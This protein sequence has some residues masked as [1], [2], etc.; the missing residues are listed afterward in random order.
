M[1]DLSLKNTRADISKGKY[2]LF[3]SPPPARRKDLRPQVCLSW[4]SFAIRLCYIRG[5]SALSPYHRTTERPIL[6]GCHIGTG[7]YT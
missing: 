3:P 5:E 7:K 6:C 1:F 2:I 4:D